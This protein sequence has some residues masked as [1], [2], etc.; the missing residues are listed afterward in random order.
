MAGGN[1]LDSARRRSLTPGSRSTVCV[2]RL[3]LASC[4]PS[5]IDHAT[6]HAGDV[7]GRADLTTAEGGDKLRAVYGAAQ[8]G[9]QQRHQLVDADARLDGAI[10]AD[11]QGLVANIFPNRLRS[12]SRSPSTG[13]VLHQRWWHLRPG[14]SKRT[15]ADATSGSYVCARAFDALYVGT[16]PLASA[17]SWHHYPDGNP[18]ETSGAGFA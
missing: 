10:S 4:S 14:S 13:T 18:S 12:H 17:A 3:T 9:S 16:C 5:V 7:G 1:G 15:R 8:P 11:N 2:S 6:A